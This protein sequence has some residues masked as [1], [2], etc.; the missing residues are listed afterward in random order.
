VRSRTSIIGGRRS[1]KRVEGG[2]VQ[3]RSLGVSHYR[4]SSKGKNSIPE[5]R[6]RAV[7]GVRGLPRRE[8]RLRGSCQKEKNLEV[9]EDQKKKWGHNARGKVKVVQLTQRKEQ[10]GNIKVTFK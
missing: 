4:L 6:E 2:Q 3:R 9:S 10:R 8:E 1:L 5:D 7:S